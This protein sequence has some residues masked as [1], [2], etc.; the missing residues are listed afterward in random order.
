MK[1]VALDAEQVALLEQRLTVAGTRLAC[2]RHFDVAEEHRLAGFPAGL[3]VAQLVGPEFPG[4][5]LAVIAHGLDGWPLL[6]AS[7]AAVDYF[8]F[9]EQAIS[10][11]DPLAIRVLTRHWCTHAAQAPERSAALAEVGRLALVTDALRGAG[12]LR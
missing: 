5:Q 2:A 6:P 10:D 1:G 11:D 7:G 9:L 8:D 3:L 12:V 4:V